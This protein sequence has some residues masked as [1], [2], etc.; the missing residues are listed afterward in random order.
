MRIA[1]TYD[2]MM[3]RHSMWSGRG[4]AAAP[5]QK[6]LGDEFDAALND[7]R[8]SLI[9]QFTPVNARFVTDSNN[10]RTIDDTL[11]MQALLIKHA[12]RKI[13]KCPESLCGES[14][15]SPTVGSQ[16]TP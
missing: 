12:G 10:S 16:R 14:D 5:P 8:D 6:K 7:Q 15:I 3:Q 13:G 9:S 4:P 11:A 1:E 2:S